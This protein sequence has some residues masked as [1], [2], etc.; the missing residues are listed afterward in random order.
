VI[1]P[2]LAGP[3]RADRNL[4]EEELIASRTGYCNEQCRVFIALCEVMQIP[5]R[6]CFLWHANGRVGHTTTEVWI[7][8]NW[9]F[10]DVTYGVRVGLPNGTFAEARELRAAYRALAHEAYRKPLGAW[11]AQSPDGGAASRVDSATG[12]DFLESIGI[13]NYL[14]EGVQQEV[15]GK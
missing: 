15:D 14:I 3:L 5:A 2:H 10:H 9:V 7:D 12:G 8:G 13:C 1:H 4:V 6:L 11:Q